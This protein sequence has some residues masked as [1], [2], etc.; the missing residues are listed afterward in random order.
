MG[1]TRNLNNIPVVNSDLIL[2]K[3]DA[4]YV[5]SF[6]NNNSYFLISPQSYNLLNLI[7]GKKNIYQITTEY[8]LA[9][10]S[11]VKPSHL[12]DVLY[13]TFESK[14]IILGNKNQKIKNN[15]P[16]YLKLSQPLLPPRLT[17]RISSYFSFLFKKKTFTYLLISCSFFLSTVSFIYFKNIILY[18]YSLSISNVVLY[19]FIGMS[20]GFIHELGHTSAAYHFKSRVGAIGFGFYLLTPVLYA[21]VSS[22]WTLNKKKRII[23]NFGGIYFE[24]IYASFLIIIAFLI[25]NKE[26]LILP[27]VLFIKTLYNLN[28]FF[29]TDGYWVLSDA[30][31]VPNLRKTSLEVLKSLLSNQKQKYNNKLK[32]YFLG[33]YAL[34][35][36]AIIYVFLFGI[37]II[38]PNS[39]V[40]FPKDLINEIKYLLNDGNFDTNRIASLLIPLTFYFLGLRLIITKFKK[41]L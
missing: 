38:S 9:T 14:N 39:L 13:S 20:S 19:L 5:I 22:I 3:R 7:D 40:T 6:K 35:S 26:L 4:E 15:V 30:L 27:L 21:D 37:I 10:K 24:L 8:N 12:H 36:S 11:E 23:V 18:F 32:Y 33:F 28:P 29:R 41:L 31:N 34:I 2:S 25:D 1:N 17:A 16:N